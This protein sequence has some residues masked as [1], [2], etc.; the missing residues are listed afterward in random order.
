MTVFTDL[1]DSPT[2]G[3][4]ICRDS[5]TDLLHIDHVSNSI[6]VVTVIM[7]LMDRQTDG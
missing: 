3:E 7:V 5:L 1:M 4:N 2:D 6:V